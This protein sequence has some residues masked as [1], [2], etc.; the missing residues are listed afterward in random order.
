MP[1]MT[2]KMTGATPAPRRKLYGRNT[3]HA[4]QIRITVQCAECKTQRQT[5]KS[6]G[7]GETYL[8]RCNECC[9]ETVH[10]PVA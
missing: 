5:G 3:Q 2:K 10:T 9:W 6:I 7:L 4:R 8:I 1:T